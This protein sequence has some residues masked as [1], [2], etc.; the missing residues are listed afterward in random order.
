[1]RRKIIS[2]ILLSLAVFGAYFGY[3][4]VKYVCCS[5]RLERI[6]MAVVIVIA[7]AR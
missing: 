2:A 1:M 5:N 7:A 4:A 6:I 3:I